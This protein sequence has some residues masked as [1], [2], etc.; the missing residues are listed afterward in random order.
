SD[1]GHHVATADH[2]RAILGWNVVTRIFG[3]G[4]AIV[5]SGPGASQ[6]ELATARP[7]HAAR[8]HH[9]TSAVHAASAHA[10]RAAAHAARAHRATRAAAH[11]AR[12]VATRAAAHA[13]CAT[14][15]SS[16]T[17]TA[18]ASCAWHVTA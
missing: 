14:T 13:A 15:C 9:A 2:S 16:S 4:R 6:I 12:A 3:V 8:A 11:A 1:G 7:H 18:R 5:A 17:V 10:T